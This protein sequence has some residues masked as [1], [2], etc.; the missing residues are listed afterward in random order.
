MLGIARSVELFNQAFRLAWPH[1]SD[2]TIQSPQVSQLLGDAIRRR[3][4]VG[5]TDPVEIAAEAV[6]ELRQRYHD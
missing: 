6:T 3:L 5:E 2:N 4:R 1:V